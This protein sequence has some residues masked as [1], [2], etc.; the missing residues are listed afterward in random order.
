MRVLY[1]LFM[2]PSTRSLQLMSPLVTWVVLV[3]M[4][5]FSKAPPR[6]HVGVSGRSRVCGAEF[7]V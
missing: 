3:E 2:A 5:L 7:S 1:F 6:H 4:N